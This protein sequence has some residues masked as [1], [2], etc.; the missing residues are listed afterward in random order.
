MNAP[1][2][3][4]RGSDPAAASDDTA[5]PAERRRAAVVAGH[6]G[7]RITARRL[8]TDPDA[9]VRAAAVGALARCA[10]LDPTVIQTAVADTDP[11][12]RRRVAE[13]LG[14]LAGVTPAARRDPEAGPDREVITGVLGLLGDDDPLVAESAAWALGE[15][16]GPIDEV[17][18]V[19]A[20]PRRADVVAALSALATSHSDPLVREAAVAALGALGD[21]GGR[22]AVLA[23]TSDK[24]AV[25]RRAVIAL[26]AFLGADGVD[27]ALA[28]ACSD[29][30]WQ[31]RQAAEVLLED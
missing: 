30:D 8:L 25:R 18:G 1:A 20:Q 26:A 9:Q 23:A 11:V 3:H 27:E 12:V 13:E 24:P 2:H 19:P 31:V 21:D 16:L 29:R 6:T 17:G 14:R 7:D 28:R 4:P 15:M 10:D 22:A 5:P